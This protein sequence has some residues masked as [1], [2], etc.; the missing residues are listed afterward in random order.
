MKPASSARWSRVRSGPAAGR[1]GAGGDRGGRRLER[2]HRGR[3]PG[4]RR[5]GARARRRVR[6][7]Q[8]GAGA[9]PGRGDRTR[10]IRSSS[11]TPTACPGRG[12]L[13]RLLARP[14]GAARTSSVAR[15]TSPGPPRRWRAATTTAA[16]TTCTPAASR[17]KSRTIRRATSASAGQPSPR[18]GGFTERQPV[19]YAHEELAW[20]AEVRRAGRPHLLRAGRRRLPPQ[21][22]RLRQSAPAQLPLGLQRDREQGADR[23]RP[24]WP[25]STAIP[26]C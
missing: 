14:R 15:S 6:R 13:A 26:D 17:A 2:R 3:G 10:A 21:P 1:G 12:W 7:R 18:T 8:S 16:G 11:S 24:A 9:E 5:A 23:R 25:G 20:Q 22:A 4:G 19:A